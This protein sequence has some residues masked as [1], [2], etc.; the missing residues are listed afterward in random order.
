[1]CVEAILEANVEVAGE[2]F[3]AW[4]KRTADILQTKLADIYPVNTGGSDVKKIKLPA[5]KGKLETRQKYLAN[6]ARGQDGGSV[7]I[8][9]IHAVK[10]ETHDLTVLVCPEPRQQS[11]CPSVVWWSDAAAVREERRI[12]FVAVTRT[13]GDLIVCVSRKSFA[14]LQTNR[15][16]F[17]DSFEQMAIDEFIA[18][19]S[20]RDKV[21]A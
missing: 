11:Q 2:H 16:E 17:F 19:N 3:E 10:G 20:A 14:R 8:Q 5:G 13:R 21:A 9:T 4:G 15:K 12:A 1:M 18:G 6:N 7:T